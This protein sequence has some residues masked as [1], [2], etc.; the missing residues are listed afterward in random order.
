MLTGFVFK[1][2][3]LRHFDCRS[4]LDVSEKSSTRKERE[5]ERRDKVN[6]DIIN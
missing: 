4:E 3:K 1:I 6:N 2:G 5:E